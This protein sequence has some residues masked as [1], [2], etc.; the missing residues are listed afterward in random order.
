MIVMR[1]RRTCKNDS[2]GHLDQTTDE[3][4][5]H[6]SVGTSHYSVS[7]VLMMRRSAIGH[8]LASLDPGSQICGLCI[9]SDSEIQRW[10]DLSMRLSSNLF[11]SQGLSTSIVTV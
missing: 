6:T 8:V 2:I 10:T 3:R 4:Q 1:T 11:S 9:D 7:S 5:S